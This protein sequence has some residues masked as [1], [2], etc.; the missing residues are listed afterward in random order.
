MPRNKH[1]II[2]TSK[3]Q[4]DAVKINTLLEKNGIASVLRKVTVDSLLASKRSEPVMVEIDE[5]DYNEAK[6]ILK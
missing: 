2:C 4:E 3:N 5:K 1:I 6:M